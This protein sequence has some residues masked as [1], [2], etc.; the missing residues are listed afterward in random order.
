VKLIRHTGGPGTI[1]RQGHL[2]DGLGRFAE[3]GGTTPGWDLPSLPVVSCGPDLTT[4]TPTE[5]DEYLSDANPYSEHVP[6]PRYDLDETVTPEQARTTLTPDV[7]QR[8]T[9][10]DCG[11]LAHYLADRNGWGVCIVGTLD[12]TEYEPGSPYDTYVGVDTLQ[13][14]YAVLPDGRLIDVRGTHDPAQ[15]DDLAADRGALRFDYPNAASADRLWNHE[16]WVDSPCVDDPDP[17]LSAAITA[18]YVTRAYAPADGAR[19][20]VSRS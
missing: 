19:G 6:V 16:A 10:G 8:Y 20:E 13:H 3:Q 14:A 5:R 9:T 2:H 17:G 11:A 7:V 12:T 1:D 15:A 4:M 18:A